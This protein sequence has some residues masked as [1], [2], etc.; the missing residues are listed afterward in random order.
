MGRMRVDAAPQGSS[1]CLDAARR[2]EVKVHVIVGP[3][4]IAHLRTSNAL[5]AS[6]SVKLSIRITS[7]GSMSTI[8]DEKFV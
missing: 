2:S 7:S 4:I 3:K 5:I 6:S 8:V 1:H